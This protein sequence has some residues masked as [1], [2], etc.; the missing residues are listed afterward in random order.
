MLQ[1][2]LYILHTLGKAYKLELLNLKQTP[3]I[4]SLYA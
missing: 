4:V 3:V 2:Q 1:F